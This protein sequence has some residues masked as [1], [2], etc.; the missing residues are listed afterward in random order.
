ML[1]EYALQ[2]KKFLSRKSRA[3]PCSGRADGLPLEGRTAENDGKSFS[4]SA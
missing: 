3:T 1:R 4:K 2:K